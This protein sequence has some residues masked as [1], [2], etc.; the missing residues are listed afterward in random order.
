MLD[1]MTFI[2][3]NSDQYIPWRTSC[4][5]P[6]LFL[7]EPSPVCNGRSDCTPWNLVKHQLRHCTFRV[8]DAAW[9]ALRNWSSQKQ[10]G[11]VS[12]SRS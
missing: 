7:E 9:P 4:T 3:V 10:L 6:V 8:W 12:L 11:T 2:V 1:P 5:V